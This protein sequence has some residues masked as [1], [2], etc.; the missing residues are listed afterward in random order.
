MKMNKKTKSRSDEALRL[1]PIMSK[2]CLH[3]STV[4]LLFFIC[5]YS[6]S[7]TNGSGR[8]GIGISSK[9]ISNQWV[10]NFRYLDGRVN[11]IFTAKNDNARLIHSSN[12]ENGTIVF[13]LYNSKNNLLMTFPANNTTDTITGIFNKGERYI[14][15]ATVSKAK[16]RF[17]FKME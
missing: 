8:V 4:F 11:G 12:L 17:E 10:Y 15:S 9:N 16:G 14:I 3:K 7:C 13:Q 6:G 1:P 2:L 5:L